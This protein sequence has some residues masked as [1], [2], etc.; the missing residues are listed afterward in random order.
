MTTDP[1]EDGDIGALLHGAVDDVQPRHDTTDV[2]ARLAGDDEA[3]A[4]PGRRSVP[5][6][7]VAAVVALLLGGL[8]WLQQSTPPPRPAAAPAVGRDLTLEVYYLGDTAAGPR[9]FSEQH[10]LHH[11]TSSTAQ[12]AVDAALSRPDDPDYRSGFPAGTRARVADRGDVVTIDLDHEVSSAPTGSAP[13]EGEAAAQALVWTLDAALQRPVPVS[14]T[15]RGVPVTTLLGSPLDQPVDQ[16]SADQQLSP[17]SLTLPQDARLRSG[18]TV[19]GDAAA[20]E[21][22]VVWELRRGGTV[23]EHGYT[24]AGQ[25]CTLSPFA[26]VLQAPAG[27]YTLSVSDTDPSD[28]HGNGVTTDT[29][30]I[31][32]D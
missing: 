13:G 28:G 2:L 1:T 29:K 25:C 18:T 9:L 21:G 5:V 26:F 12:A 3:S 31:R 24:T 23:V 27:G 4:A 6:L 32:I 14:I 22:N 17:V 20:Y 8:A 10:V 16:G 7:A 19:R 30:A 11:V 15:V